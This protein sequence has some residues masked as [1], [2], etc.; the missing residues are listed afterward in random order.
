MSIP[1]VMARVGD[2]PIGKFVVNTYWYSFSNDCI[3]VSIFHCKSLEFFLLECKDGEGYLRDRKEE[4][5]HV[6]SSSRQASPL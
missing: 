6:L 2:S 3:I 4:T 5:S 1:C